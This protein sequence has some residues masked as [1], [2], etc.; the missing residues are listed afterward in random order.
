MKSSTL[1]LIALGLAIVAGLLLFVS[2]YGKN[3]R[4][5]LA[6]G[7]YEQCAAAGYP[8]LETY[9]TQC[10]TPDGRTFVNTKEQ[11]TPI[12]P[13]SDSGTTTSGGCIVG[14]C[15]QELCTDAS[16]GPAISPC[17]YQA[18]FACYKGATCERQASG[19][20]GWTPTVELTSCLASS[21]GSD[22]MQVQ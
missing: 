18:E 4:A 22:S 2:S 11:V 7:S 10:R 9:P 8:I 13:P 19:Q 1:F 21:T 14:G 5:A 20:C 15:S 12:A 6:V 3:M 16:D 17:I